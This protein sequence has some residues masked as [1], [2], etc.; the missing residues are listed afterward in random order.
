[1]AE[2]WDETTA[3]LRTFSIVIA[4]ATSA[5]GVRSHSSCHR[6]ASADTWYDYTFPGYGEW[7]ATHETSDYQRLMAISRPPGIK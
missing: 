6:I 2:T 3:K 5:S 1:M 4:T 7:M